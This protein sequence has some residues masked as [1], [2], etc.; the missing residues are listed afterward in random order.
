MKITLIIFGLL[1]SL[2]STF[3][4]ES[5]LVTILRTDNKETIY[6]NLVTDDLGDLVKI[7]VVSEKRTQSATVEKILSG[8]TLFTEKAISVIKIKSSDLDRVHGG[9]VELKYLKKFR[10]FRSNI[11]GSVKLKILKDNAGLWHLYHSGQV[12]KQIN[13][14]P[15]TWGIRKIQLN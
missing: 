7:N 13:I 11:F 2:K 1:I 8:A 10:I 15:Y 9:H 4:F 3:A 6:L 14:T 12:V 5:N